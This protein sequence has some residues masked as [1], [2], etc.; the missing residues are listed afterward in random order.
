MK[1]PFFVSNEARQLTQDCLIDNIRDLLG[2]RATVRVRA[3]LRADFNKKALQCKKTMFYHLRASGEVSRRGSA[4][5]IKNI[6][7]TTDWILI[8]QS[9]NND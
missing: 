8:Q 6:E 3:R 4:Q 1:R 2:K 5:W 7:F 9:R